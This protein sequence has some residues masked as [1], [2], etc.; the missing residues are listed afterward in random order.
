MKRSIFLVFLF[1]C[2]YFHSTADDHH[3]NSKFLLGDWIQVEMTMRDGSRVVY[4]ADDEMPALEYTITPNLIF[5]Q[6]TKHQVRTSFSYKYKDAWLKNLYSAQEYDIKYRNDTLQLLE[7]HEYLE[8]DRLRKMVFVR[9]QKFFSNYLPKYE[10]QTIVTDQYTCP[11][12]SGSFAKYLFKK[13]N[14][15]PGT[16]QL[17]GYIILDRNAKSVTPF[18]KE[19]TRKTKSLSK[20]ITKQLNKSYQLWKFKPGVVA[21]RYKIYFALRLDQNGGYRYSMFHLYNDER[22][23]MGSELGEDDEDEDKKP[24]S[25]WKARDYLA[26]GIKAFEDKDYDLALEKFTKSCENDPLL[27]DAFYNKA[28]LHLELGEI[29]EACEAWRYL[30]EELGQ[31]PAQKYLKKYC[32]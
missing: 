26:E 18:F 6:D 17:E 31:V 23:L 11:H 3:T 30:G 15:R 25:S 21:Q 10:D 28:A 2:C 7:K 22:I 8:D 32:K 29:E 5:I 4:A 16:R 12:F 1:F 20:K 13:I 9:R 19:V 24:V 27:L 14:N